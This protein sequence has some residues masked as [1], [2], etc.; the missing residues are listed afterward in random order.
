VS[1]QILTFHLTLS[2]IGRLK[3][4]SLESIVTGAKMARHFGPAAEHS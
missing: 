3:G 4:E 2:L 1:E